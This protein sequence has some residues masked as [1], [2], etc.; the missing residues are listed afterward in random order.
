MRRRPRLHR[1][2]VLTVVTRIRDA[3]CRLVSAVFAAAAA[4]FAVGMTACLIYVLYVWLFTDAGVAGCI[5]RAVGCL[6]LALVFL[7]LSKVDEIEFVPATTT[8]TTTQRG[9]AHRPTKKAT[10]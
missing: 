1:R 6:V 5:G 3:A 2:A 10:P 4:A 9:G 8:T 7:F